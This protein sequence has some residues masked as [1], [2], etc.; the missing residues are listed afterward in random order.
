MLSAQLDEDN[1]KD[2]K[3]K[4]KYSPPPLTVSESTHSIYDEN[5]QNQSKHFL[6]EVPS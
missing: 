3:L 5:L 1:D 2:I 6:H 4:F